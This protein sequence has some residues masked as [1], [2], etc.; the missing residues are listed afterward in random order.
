[1]ENH[2]AGLYKRRV[3]HGYFTRLIMRSDIII[4]LCGTL[5]EVLFESVRMSKAAG[6]W[7][8]T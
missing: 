8:A 1:M 7:E 2:L 5:Q 4:D 6:G 3:Q